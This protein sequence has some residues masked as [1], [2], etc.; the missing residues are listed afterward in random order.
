MTM[1]E[2]K[3]GLLLV[4]KCMNR[5]RLLLDINNSLQALG[6]W[7]ILNLIKTFNIIQPTHL[8]VLFIPTEQTIQN[9]SF[10]IKGCDD[11]Q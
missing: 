5:P 2:N 1:A 3:F 11:A 6:D 10:L 4:Q 8:K 9:T 7:V